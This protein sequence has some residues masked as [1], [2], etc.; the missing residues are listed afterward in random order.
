LSEEILRLVFLHTCFPFALSL[1]HQILLDA[2]LCAKIADFGTIRQDELGTSTHI[3]TE[4]VIGTRC[5]MPPEYVAGGEISVKT[6]SFAF[7]IVLC[8]LLTGIN[9]M[10][11]PLRAMLDDALETETLDD[12][13]DDQVSSWDMDIARALASIALR[14]SESTKSRRATVQVVLPELERLRNPSYMPTLAV[15]NSYYH[16]DT[17][18]LVRE[19]EEEDE[20]GGAN[21]LENDGVVHLRVP[22]LPLLTKQG[23]DGADNGTHGADGARGGSKQRWL[24]I[25]VAFVLGV[26]GVFIGLRMSHHPHPHTPV[27]PASVG[28]CIG[29]SLALRDDCAAWQHTV[30][31][32]QYFR[33]ASPPAC[34]EAHHVTDPCSCAGVISCERDRIVAVALTSRNLTFDMNDDTSLSH[35]THLQVINLT[36]NSLTGPLPSWLQ[37][38][39]TSLVRLDLNTNL[40]AGTID[41]VKDLRSL[42]TLRLGMNPFNDTIDALAQLTALHHLNVNFLRGPIGGLAGLK[43]LTHLDLYQGA[44]GVLHADRYLTG[45]INAL[46]QLTS[47]EYVMLG[48]NHLTGTIDAVKELKLL[49]TLDLEANHFTGTI[50]AVKDL[51]SLRDLNLG[52][53]TFM[54]TIDAASRL[55]N[56]HD[57]NLCNGNF[58]GTIDAVKQLTALSSLKLS[59]NKFTGS[60]DAVTELSGLTYLNLNDQ[61]EHCDTQGFSG[62]IPSQL[63]ELT[64]LVELDLGSNQ[65]SG[66]IP[67]ELGRLTKLATLD[68]GNQVSETREKTLTGT[69]PTELG[70]L[71]ALTGLQFWYNQLTGSIPPQLAEMTGLTHLHLQKNQFMGTIDPVKTLTNLVVLE[72]DDNQFKGPIDAVAQLKSLATLQLRYNQFTGSIDPIQGLTSLISMDAANNQLS[73]DIGA[74]KQ[75]TDITSL[76]LGGN[77]FTGPVTAVADLTKLTYLILNW[78]AYSHH[79]DFSGTLPFGPVDWSKI[80]N[81]HMGGNHF[82]CPLPAGAVSHCGATCQHDPCVGGSRV[83]TLAQ[84][85]AWQDFFD[86]TNGKGWKQ[87]T[88]SRLDP[89]SCTDHVMCANGDITQVKLG[90]NGLTGTISSSLE[91][92]T[93]LTILGLIGNGL[94]GTIPSSLGSLTS[95]TDLK[96]Y[97]NELTGTIP[98]SLASLTSLTNILLDQNKLTGTVPPLPF[99]R[100]TGGCHLD[101]STCT[102]PNCNHFRCPLPAGSEHC[103]SVHCK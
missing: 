47:L 88:G 41:A 48:N 22:L 52:D 99:V 31:H 56:L 30:L 66:T 43:Q 13:L 77:N 81:C 36:N 76:D 5:Y 80:G 78:P 40:L 71:T 68:L 14:C 67:T 39:A 15:G 87:Y 70:K 3:K 6:D 79:N 42:T 97:G 49:T 57:L 34:N 10:A 86:A 83:L 19:G 2:N 46:A 16:P 21:D 91:L 35:L 102:E 96:L 20:H 69:I 50:D 4:T 25:L 90:S 23:S 95:L 89:C 55:T 33:L 65:I 1:F 98:S 74:L 61:I 27:S 53:N 94:T 64:G 60:I 38:L 29:A 72:L 82:T 103:D 58:T 93:S 51:I 100:Y 37:K 28:G 11:K 85:G 18:L 7:G 84:C 73:G 101:Y 24:L 62:T 17:G 12:V 9:P 54:G 44:G 32:S 59:R 26:A 92:L 8:E 63:G 75:L 45:P